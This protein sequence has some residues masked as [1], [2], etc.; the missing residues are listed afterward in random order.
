MNEIPPQHDITLPLKPNEQKPKL[1][2][3]LF[4][5]LAYISILFLVPL[6]LSAKGT[7]ERFH[8][9]QG[10]VLFVTSA[11]VLTISYLLGPSIGSVLFATVIVLEVSLAIIGTRN[12]LQGSREGLPFLDRI[13]GI[14]LHD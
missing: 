8:S 4:G 11:L 7:F 12:I 13:A 6:F 2:T 5:L 14:F 1:P 10:G 3:A 9:V